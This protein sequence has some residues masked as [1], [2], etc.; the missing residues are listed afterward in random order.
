MRELPKMM[1]ILKM[2][3][4]D[5]VKKRTNLGQLLGQETRG[6]SLKLKINLMKLRQLMPHLVQR[7]MNQLVRIQ[8]I[9]L[10]KMKMAP[11]SK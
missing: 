8:I 7:Q 10:N 1:T 11:L 3:Q 9:P 6:L 4:K 2:G 5:K